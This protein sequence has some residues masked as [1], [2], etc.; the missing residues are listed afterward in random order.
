MTRQGQRD[1]VLAS[2]FPGSDI[3]DEAGEEVKGE[4]SQWKEHINHKEN[5]EGVVF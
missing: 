1:L 4:R 3:H 5:A 2:P